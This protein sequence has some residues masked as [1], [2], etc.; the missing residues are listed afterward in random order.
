MPNS[1]IHIIMTFITNILYYMFYTRIYKFK[2]KN[3]NIYFV[4]KYMTKTNEN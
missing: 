2:F 3:N 4:T 1:N